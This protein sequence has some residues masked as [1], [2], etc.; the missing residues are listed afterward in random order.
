MHFRVEHLTPD[1]AWKRRDEIA[2]VY[3]AA[4]DVEQIVAESFRDVSLQNVLDYPGAT[5]IAAIARDRILGF[6]YGYTYVPGHWWPIHVGPRLEAEGHGALLENTFELLELAVLPD[7]QGKGIGTALLRQLFAT[8]PHDHV[9]LN[10][11]A[12]EDNR[13]VD[14]YRRLGFRVLISDFQ[15]M[16]HG[17]ENLIMAWSRDSASH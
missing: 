14:L 10:T 3:G 9:L 13:A 1:L 11:N 4:F 2:A 17:D 5:V 7:A 12:R 6:L 8:M 16:K 15:Y